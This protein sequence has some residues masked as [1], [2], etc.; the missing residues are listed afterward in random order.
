MINDFEVAF[1]S[2]CRRRWRSC[3]SLLNGDESCVAVVIDKD[4]EGSVAKGVDLRDILSIPG[5]FWY[6][7]KYADRIHRIL[8]G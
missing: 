2:K 1:D 6:N 7:N 4:E 3:D 8:F 5:I